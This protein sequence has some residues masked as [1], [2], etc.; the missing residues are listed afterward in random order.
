MLEAMDKHLSSWH[1]HGSP[2]VCG[3]AW[4]HDRFLIVAVDEAAT[5][6]SGCSVDGLFGV[7]NKIDAQI[8][9][10]LVDRGRIYWRN[11]SNSVVAGSRSEF[12]RAYADGAITD[13]TMVF[14]TTVSNIGEWQSRFER[15]LAESWHAR[16]VKVTARANP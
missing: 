5:G 12:A 15:P 8:G 6:A 7:L 16:L 10:T 11:A 1:A 4:Q 13:S 14:D 3:R 9:T 2:L